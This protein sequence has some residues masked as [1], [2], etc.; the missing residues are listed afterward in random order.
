[1]TV[2]WRDSKDLACPLCQLCCWPDPVGKLSGPTQWGVVLLARL[3][4]P[5]LV[6]ASCRRAGGM[7][8]MIRISATS[9]CCRQLR[10]WVM[11]MPHSLTLTLTVNHKP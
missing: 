3:N 7:T 8:T 2:I 1:M 6:N 4:G 11:A 9:D 5:S 10:R